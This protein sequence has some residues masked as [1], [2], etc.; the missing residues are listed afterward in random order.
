M[1]A[2][3]WVCGQLHSASR[4]RPL[5]VELLRLP[6]QGVHKRF[7]RNT[8]RKPRVILNRGAFD[9]LASEAN[10]IHQQ[11]VK[12][13]AGPIDGGGEPSRPATNNHEVVIGHPISNASWSAFTPPRSW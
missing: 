2:A 8:V 9:R 11:Y 1:V 7:A 3:K 4:H 12:A 13:L 10:S 6:H 5:R